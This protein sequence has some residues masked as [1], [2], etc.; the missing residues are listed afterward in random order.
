[1]QQAIAACRAAEDPVYAAATRGG[2]QAALAEC[3]GSSW[4]KAN[5]DDPG[6]ARFTALL[7]SA[8]PAPDD[9]SSAPAARAWTQRTAPAADL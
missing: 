6:V 1:M 5:T 9:G 8:E 7:D 2:L 4:L 3:A